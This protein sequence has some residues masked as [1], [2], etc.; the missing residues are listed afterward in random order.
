MPLAT[1]PDWREILDTLRELETTTL[2]FAFHGADAIHDRAVMRQGAYRESLRAVE[3]TRGVGMRTGCNLFLTKENIP[4][5]DRL[6]AD[7]QR[8]GMQEIIPHVYN[9]TPNARGR[10]CEPLRPDWRDVEPL[11]EKLDAIPE[12]CLWRQFWHELPQR[13]TEAWYVAQ[14]GAGSWPDE[15]REQYEQAYRDMVSLVCRSNLDVYSGFAGQY[16]IRYGN[17]RRDWGRGRPQP[18][19]ERWHMFLRGHLVWGSAHP[20]HQGTCHAL[21]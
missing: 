8:A 9:F 21:R 13:H 6:V 5:F 3:L 2:W 17:L 18:R 14:A 20:A 1:R 15:E 10:H 7:L 11:V 12:T 4:Q 16:S 19:N